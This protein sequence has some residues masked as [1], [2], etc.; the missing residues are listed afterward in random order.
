MKKCLI[1]FIILTFLF[2]KFNSDYI[3][4]LSIVNIGINQTL[5]EEDFLSNILSRHLCADFIIGSYKEKI[6]AVINMSQ[7]GFF[8]YDQS[9][10]Y[11]SSF[12]FKSTGKIR[13]FYYKNSEEGYDANDTLCFAEYEKNKNLDDYDSS[14]FWLD[15]AMSE[16]PY[17]RDPFMER[18]LLEYKY[19]NWNNVILYCLR[20]LDIDTHP[21]SYINEVFSFDSTVYDLL[22]I[23]YYNIGIY[24]KALFYVEKAIEMNPDDERLLNNKKV[25]LE[26]LNV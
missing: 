3:L 18:A 21:K 2:T 22:S 4:P 26:I 24:D 1:P 9:Y 14:C 6:R 5:L 23:S 12:S 20:A 16:A 25:F 17:L 8:I 10:D 7:I 13:S 11:L 19:E 15:K